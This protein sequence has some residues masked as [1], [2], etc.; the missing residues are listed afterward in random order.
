[1]PVSSAVGAYF[2][3]R[4][5]SANTAKNNVEFANSVSQSMDKAVVRIYEERKSDDDI[6]KLIALAKDKY[7]NKGSL[8]ESKTMLQAIPS[9]SRMRAKADQLLTQWEEDIKKNNDLSQKV[10]KPT[11]DAKWQVAIDTFKGISLAPYWQQWRGKEIIE[12]KKNLPNPVVPASPSV[13]TPLTN[14]DP[15]HNSTTEPYTPP[16]EAP[17]NIPAAEPYPPTPEIDSSPTGYTPN[18]ESSTPP[19][20]PAPRVAK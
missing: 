12:S 15:P 2:Y 7:E 13:S 9:D 1:L 4:S 17:H 10:D 11:K 6:E 19:L 5:Q 16:A 20:P 14:A 18:S 8:T 3:M